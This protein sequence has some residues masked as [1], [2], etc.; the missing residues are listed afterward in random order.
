MCERPLILASSGILDNTN[1]I[2]TG[3]LP[4]P[5]QT[6]VALVSSPDSSMHGTCTWSSTSNPSLSTITSYLDSNHCI[7]NLNT[8]TTATY[9]VS[10]T[11]C[12]TTS[13]TSLTVSLAEFAGE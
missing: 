12:L 7:A 1:T 9:T 2:Y 5:G 10:M 8:S 3:N 13:S 4:T 6:T 11:G